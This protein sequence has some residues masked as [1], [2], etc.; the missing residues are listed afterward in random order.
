MAAQTCTLFLVRH[1]Q[2]QWNVDKIIQGHT[3]IPL[4][5]EGEKQAHEQRI[6]LKNIDFSKVYSSDL[7]RAQRTA[8]ILNFERK[9]S[10]DI[11]PALRERNFGMYEGR[12]REEDKSKV[13]ELLNKNSSHPHLKESQVE[14]NESMLERSL[15][16]L[17][18]ISKRHFGQNILV[19][20]HGGLIRQILIHLGYAKADDFQP[21]AIKNLAFIKMECDGMNFLIKETSGIVLENK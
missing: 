8:E 10:H 11:S 3:N 16:Y 15:F 21:K 2:T 12:S 17:K 7:L 20:S 1:G 18:S 14:S 13:F 19:V 5:Q 4:N 9:L 6:N